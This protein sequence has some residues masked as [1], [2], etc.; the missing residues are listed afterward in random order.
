[1]PLV[2]NSLTRSGLSENPP[3]K[4]P[5]ATSLHLRL[6][7]EFQKV[8]RPGDLATNLPV[9]LG[10]RR[11]VFNFGRVYWPECV[12]RAFVYSQSDQV[13][14]F[15]GCKEGNFGCNLLASFPSNDNA[16]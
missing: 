9:I 16:I 4:S 3:E 12:S 13:V 8:L 15:I 10:K 1:M 6:R 5:A 14:R 7:L 11:L 2:S